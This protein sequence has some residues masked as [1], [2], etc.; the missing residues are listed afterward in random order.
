MGPIWVHSWKCTPHFLLSCQRKRAVHGPKEKRFSSK[1]ARSGKFGDATVESQLSAILPGLIQVRCTLEII[2]PLSRKLS[3][4]R[5]FQGAYRSAPLLAPLPL[6]WG[7]FPKRGPQPP[8]LVVLRGGLEGESRNP[9]PMSLF[10][11]R[12]VQQACLRHVCSVDPLS[13][14]ERGNLRWCCNRGRI[15]PQ[16]LSCVSYSCPAGN[17]SSLQN[18]PP[19]RIMSRLED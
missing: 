17:L 18:N 8:L 14:A 10:D 19:E 7:V 6:R 1:L 13:C 15:S 12:S 11:R 2:Q 5:K 9:P 3:R 16:L 4:F